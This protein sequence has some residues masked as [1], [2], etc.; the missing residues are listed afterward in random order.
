[1][2]AVNPEMI[3]LAREA[4]GLTIRELAKRLGMS[5]AHLSRHESGLMS[6]S[7]DRL[8]Q[9]ADELHR[10]ATYF[11]R[12]GKIY[13]ASGLYHRKQQRVRLR[14]LKMIHAH[15]NELRMQAESLLNHAEVESDNEFHRFNLVECGGVEE[16]A[17]RLRHV[18]QLP[19][20]PIRSMVEAIESA[21]GVVF[22]CEFSSKD[23]S[24][25]SQWPL[26]N[27]DLPPVFFVNEDI[28]GDRQRFTLAH[29]LAHVIL[30]HLPSDDPEG[31]ADHFASEFLMPA[32]EIAPDLSRMTLQKAADLKAYWRV[33]MQAIIR[34]ARDLRK[35]TDRHY[36]TL[37]TQ[38]SK[39]GYRKCEPIPIPNEEPD[40]FPAIV[41][42]H[43]AHYRRPD[44]EISDMLGMFESEF[45][46][47]YG[48]GLTGLRLKVV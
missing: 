48:H 36:R 19:T 29:E 18:W 15:V 33:S 14:E 3:V 2:P 47:Q 46:S 32:A 25:I 22:R 11:Y 10:P 20:G 41:E 44:S 7:D 13:P 31:E 40:L 45:T 1:M 4:E 6:V 8:R 34:R 38:L 5:K 39:L 42:L 24:G 30:H 23:V 27:P 28:P 37:M 26:D 35:I 16:V 21:G 12:R 17:R 43:R 9:I